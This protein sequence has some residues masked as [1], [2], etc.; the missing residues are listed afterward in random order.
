MLIEQSDVF[1]VPAGT[2]KQRR[3]TCHPSQESKTV[4]ATFTFYRAPIMTSLPATL[5]GASLAALLSACAGPRFP[6]DVATVDELVARLG[7]PAK[8]WLAEGGGE[9]L[10]FTTAPHGTHTWMAVADGGGRVRSVENV[11]D[12]PH[13]ARIQPG[14]DEDEVMREIGPPY[15]YW[16]V[17]YPARNERVWEWR[18][19]DVWNEP[20]RFDV[21]FDTGT[22]KVRSTMSLTER[23][24]LYGSGRRTE[25]CS[26]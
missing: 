16:T 5:V 4:P 18:Y 11:L 12:M 8:R 3:G 25:W 17:T 19:C 9:R 1:Y 2:I 23:Q 13:F 10:A 7:P 22:G 26:P 6:A 21:L 20:A 24:S 14:M 15:P